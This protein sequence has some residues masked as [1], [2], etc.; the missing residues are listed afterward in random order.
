[1][2]LQQNNYYVND[3]LITR[4][5]FRCFFFSFMNLLKHPLLVSINRH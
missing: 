4:S 3:G 5:I 2:E 1:M